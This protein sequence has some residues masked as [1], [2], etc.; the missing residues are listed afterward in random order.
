MT[1][2]KKP[3]RPPSA[4]PKPKPK[5]TVAYLDAERLRQLE[6]IVAFTGGGRN[7]SRA[8]SQAISFHHAHLK[9]EWPN[10][11]T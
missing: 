1:V 7:N 10:D 8:I 5:A 11:F 3:G 6:E 2:K 9:K 4:N